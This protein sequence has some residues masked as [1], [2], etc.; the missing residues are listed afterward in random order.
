[1]VDLKTQVFTRALC[2][3]S[4]KAAYFPDQVLKTFLLLYLGPQ[5]E[6]GK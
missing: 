3:C 6:C 2:M 5:N 4:L 1:M